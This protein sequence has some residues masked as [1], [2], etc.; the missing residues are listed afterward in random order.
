M[1]IKLL[2]IFLCSFFSV[3]AHGSEIIVC[4][5]LQLSY[6]QSS[7]E[8]TILPK[9]DEEISGGLSGYICNNSR[10][11]CSRVQLRVNLPSTLKVP[12]DEISSTMLYF[13]SEQNA[14]DNYGGCQWSVNM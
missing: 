12:K 5:P 8:L 4:V 2:P 3:F 13:Q 11:A 6:Q 7:S 9:S 10:S 1:K 14:K